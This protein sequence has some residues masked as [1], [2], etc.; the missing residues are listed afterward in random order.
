MSTGKQTTNTHRMPAIPLAVSIVAVFIILSG[1]LGG[2]AGWVD[3]TVFFDFMDGVNWDEP[4]QR[5]LNGL[6]GTRNVGL[7]VVLL[8]GLLLQNAWVLWSGFLA[9]T[10][11]EFQDMFLLPKE[12]LTVTAALDP[13]PLQ[14]LM[15]LFPLAV[16]CMEL[17]ALLWLSWLLFKR[18]SNIG[19]EIP[20]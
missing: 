3:P 16:F 2:Y 20:D 8:A 10:V 4:N 12:Q 14:Q 11:I 15:T 19:R 9:R 13:S 18:K 1:L 5:F 6:W 7:V 17:I